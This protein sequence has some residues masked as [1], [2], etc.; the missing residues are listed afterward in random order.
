MSSISMLLIVQRYRS[1]RHSCK[2]TT[3]ILVWNFIKTN[4]YEGELFFW[5]SGFI[6]LV[7]IIH[8]GILC[9]YLWNN[10]NDKTVYSCLERFLSGYAMSSYFFFFSINLGFFNPNLLLYL[11]NGVTLATFERITLDKLIVNKYIFTHTNGLTSR[12]L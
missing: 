7:I 5:Q 4:L 12:G 11:S 2:T 6:E 3:M 10:L 8:A 9:I 1:I